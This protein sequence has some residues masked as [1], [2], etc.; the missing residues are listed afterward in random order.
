MK[1]IAFLFTSWLILPAFQLAAAGVAGQ[2]QNSSGDPLPFAAVFVEETGSGTVANEDGY[3]EIKLSP[4]RYT[5]IFQYLGYET[6]SRTVDV[7][8]G[9]FSTIN[10][11]LKQQVV[12]LKTVVVSSRQ[13]DPAYTVMRRAIAKAGFHRQQIENYTARVYVKGSGRIKKVPFFLRNE[14]KKEGIDSSLAFVSES[15]SE[16]AYQRPSTFK[17]KVISIRT[18]GDDNNTSPMS[19]INGSFYEPEIA[20][21]ISPLSPKAFAYYK[22]KHAGYFMDRGYGVNKIQ[23]I[24]RSQGD[25]VVSGYIYIIEDLWSIY[26]LDLRTYKMGIGV[27]VEQTYAPVAE[28]AWLPIKHQ[29]AVEGTFFGVT[30]EYKYLAT[31][32]NY[33]VALNPA[34]DVSFT[35]LDEKAAPEVAKAPSRNKTKVSDLEKKLSEGQEVT[36]KELR[37]MVREY[38]KEDQK[39]DTLSGF[40]AVTSFSVDTFAR[41]RDSLYWEEIRPVPLSPFEVKGYQFVDSIAIARAAEKERSD[42]LGL[43]P[44]A[45]EELEKKR[46]KFKPTDLLMGGS[47]PLGDRSRFSLSPLLANLNFN[48]VEGFHTW[49]TLKFTSSWQKKHR[50]TLD[51]T[52][53]YAHEPR[54]LSAKAGLEYRLG[55]GAKISAFRVEGGR[56]IFQFNEQKTISEVLNTYYTLFQ[57]R[58]YIRL[59]EKDYLKGTFSQSLGEAWRLGAGLEW[60]E[61]SIPGNRTA[62]VW[63]GKP[64]RSFDANIPQN[65]EWAGP[66]SEPERAFILNAFVEAKPW[67]KYRMR[68]GV[69]QVE[70]NSSPSLQLHYRKGI[71]GVMNSVTDYDLLDFRFQHRFR[72]GARG[73]VDLKAEMGVF[74]N[75]T[76]AG[77]ADYRHFMGNRIPLVTAD[78][79]GSFRL[80]DYYRHSTARQYAALHAHYQFRKLLITRIPKVWMMGLKENVFVNYL[81]TPSSKHYTELGYSIDNILRIFRVE[82]VFAFQDGRYFDWGIRI[83]IASNLGFI[84]FD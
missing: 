45:A 77:F 69:R 55:T 44:E 33:K 30:F 32:S 52:P 31:V 25:N 48:V 12:Q 17:E 53:R 15:V 5:L 36:M 62:Q 67:L 81:A 26:S 29:F 24:P 49:T 65:E 78:P 35:V 56:Y 61:R 73:T 4:G 19:F 9:P 75:S 11:Q 21:V 37:K 68:N 51:A 64:D 54:Q 27:D 1:T 13:E 23:V 22:F 34:L 80:L 18:Q 28:K 66:I 84:R 39:T 83:G 8:S 43:A 2:I 59:Y 82:S 50:I 42:S 63:Y 79:V 76:Y 70:E 16:I 58:N 38:E 6:A 3:F 14:F 40:T 74:L 46:D 47:Y 72:A 57:E 20:E 7:S 60:A 41:K 71:A 10:I